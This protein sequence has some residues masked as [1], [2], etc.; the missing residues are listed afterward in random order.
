M[1]DFIPPEHGE[2]EPSSLGRGS[3]T[4]NDEDWDGW[5][6]DV[7]VCHHDPAKDEELIDFA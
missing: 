5:L 3:N 2:P 7:A 1:L 4:Y 6:E